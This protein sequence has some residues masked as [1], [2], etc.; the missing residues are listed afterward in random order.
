[1]PLATRPRAARKFGDAAAALK[2]YVERVHAQKSRGDM[3]AETE[4]L[5]VSQA[6]LLRT[7]VADA[8]HR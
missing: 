2:T 5:L 3:A 7:R 8:A 4:T 1:M 6:E